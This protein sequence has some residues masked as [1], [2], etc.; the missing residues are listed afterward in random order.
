MEIKSTLTNHSGQVLN[1]TYR[2]IESEKDLGDKKIRVY[3]RTVST[4]IS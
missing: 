3:M 1:V 2:D 4:K